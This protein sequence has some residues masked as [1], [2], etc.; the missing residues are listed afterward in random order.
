MDGPSKSKSMELRGLSSRIVHRSRLVKE[1][2]MFQARGSVKYTHHYS[3]T[4]R[5]SSL[6]RRAARR[7]CAAPRAPIALARGQHRHRATPWRTLYNT[8]SKLS[9]L[10][11]ASPRPPSMCAVAGYAAARP[12]ALSHASLQGQL[13]AEHKAHLLDAQLR[14]VPAAPSNEG[15]LLAS[16]HVLAAG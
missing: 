13:C 11:P 15:R 8:S 4:R 14:A 6:T 2:D 7:S 16:S 12:R 3:R 1:R 5:R 9:C 10:V